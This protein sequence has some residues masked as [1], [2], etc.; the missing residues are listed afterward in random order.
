MTS[1]APLNHTVVSQAEWLEAGRALLQ[2]EKEFTRA[3]D[4][5]S[6]ARRELP[7]MKVETDY[8][9]EGPD[10]P[11]SLSDL[12]DGRSHLIVYHYMYGPGW[13]DGCP[14]CSFVCDHV[15]SARQHFEHH[16]VAYV[17][18]SRAPV[19]DFQAFKERMGWTFRWV[20]SSQNSFNYDFGVSYRREDLDA[21]PVLHNFVP[22]KLNSE[23]QPGLSVFL[24]D[25]DGSIYRTYSTYER[26]LDLLIGAY[27]YLDLMPL[28]RNEEGPMNWVQFHDK[29]ED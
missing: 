17:V 15:D 23:E 14:G 16:D 3:R 22:Q 10:G 8:V 2:K 28:G 27:N 24:K 12:F 5:M 13:A 9:F 1:I 6:A 19:A 29:Y 26:G 20:S 4:A 25:A 11:V 21:G 7:W 18:V